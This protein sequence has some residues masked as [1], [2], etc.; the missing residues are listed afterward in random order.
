MT[1]KISTVVLC[2]LLVALVGVQTDAQTNVSTAA[3]A[4]ATTAVVG[5]TAAPTATSS[6]LHIT[7]YDMSQ[8]SKGLGRILEDILIAF[9]VVVVMTAALMLNRFVPAHAVAIRAFS[10]DIPPPPSPKDTIILQND[11]VAAASNN[12]NGAVVTTPKNHARRMSQRRRRS[13]GDEMAVLDDAA[14]AFL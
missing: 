3:T 11:S 9:S 2:M 1:L 10:N 13:S 5:T 8:P 14:C 6:P 4:P 7:T 12:A